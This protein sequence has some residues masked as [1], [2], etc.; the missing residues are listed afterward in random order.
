MSESNTPNLKQSNIRFDKVKK[1]SYIVWQKI[2]EI[3]FSLNHN[4]ATAYTNF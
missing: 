1:P 4:D 2:P 3:K